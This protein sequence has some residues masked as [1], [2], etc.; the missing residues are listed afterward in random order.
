MMTAQD[1][2]K[3]ISTKANTYYTI[4]DQHKDVLAA[5]G[6]VS[7]EA[8]ATLFAHSQVLGDLCRMEDEYSS[9]EEFKELIA[10][11]RDYYT[12]AGEEYKNEALDEIVYDLRWIYCEE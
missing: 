2:K 8:S 9:E 10:D 7:R 4:Y 6:R 3:F 11:L 5:I 1:I 12:A